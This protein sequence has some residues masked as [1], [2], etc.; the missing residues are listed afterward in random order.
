MSLSWCA[1]LVLLAAPVGSS[2]SESPDSYVA[3]GIRQVKE[4]DL[5]TALFTLDTAVR[6]LATQPGHVADLVQAYVYLGVAY[7]GLNHDQAAKGKFREALK[8]D[9]GLRLSPDEFSA[10]VIKVF[11]TQLLK[12]TAAEKK[13]GAR[14]FLLLGGAGAAAAVGIAAASSQPALPPNRAPAAAIAVSPAGQAI[15]GVT[16][17]GFTANASDPDGD[18]L[19][20]AWD[21]GDGGSGSGATAT[22]IYATEGMFTVKLTVSDG[23]GGEAAPPSASVTVRTL[24][25]VWVEDL[26]RCVDCNPKYREHVCGQSGSTLRCE[27]IRPAFTGGLWTLYFYGSVLDPRR[28]QLQVVSGVPDGRPPYD[29]VPCEG[30]FASDLESGVCY[31]PAGAGDALRITRR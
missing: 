7:V 31:F 25:G 18:P 14:T 1:L 16:A 20:Y 5:E 27:V 22:H 21:F 17:M 8:L 19:T 2:A 10:R 30:E 15:V 29:P 13:R 3:M 9:P 28:L 11:E 24:T 23:H 12:K 4:G 26:G 6:R